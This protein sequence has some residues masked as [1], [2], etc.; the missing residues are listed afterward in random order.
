[1]N[2]QLKELYLMQEQL[3][4][5]IHNQHH[6]TYESTFYERIMALLVEL[7]ELANETRC[8]KYWSLK[9][10]SSKEVI[11]EEYSDGL[12]FILSL[13]IH[14]G[15]DYNEVFT[16]LQSRT[17]LTKAFLDLYAD[18][19]AFQQQTTK[20]NYRSLVNHF[21]GLGLLMDIQFSDLF[22]AYVAKNKINYERQKTNY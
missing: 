9:K 5:T 6:K 19:I 17:V 1:M 22:A 10:A 20:D 4:K 21:L 12:H 14:L 16:P 11:L 3:D 13:G 2:Y 8:F 7:G 18:V 15:I